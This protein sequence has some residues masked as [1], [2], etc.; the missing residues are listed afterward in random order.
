MKKIFTL[1]AV[2]FAAISL[3]AGELK[4]GTNDSQSSY[5]PVYVTW[6]DAYYCSQILY[7]ASELEALEGQKITHLAF[8]LRAVNTGGDYADVQIRFK[9]V[10]FDAFEEAAYVAIDDAVLVYEGALPAGSSTDLNV[11]L[12]EPYEY[13]GGT[14]LVDVRKTVKGGAYAPISGNAG[15]FQSTSGANYTVLYN[16][17]S[18]SFP[19]SASRSANRPDIRFTYEEGAV[20]ACDKITSLAASDVTAHEATLTWECEAEKYL[21]V[22]VLKGEEPA[23]TDNSQAVKTV[24]L[25]ALKSNTEYDFYVRS[26]CGEEQLGAPK[27]VSF[28]TEASCFAPLSVEA[29]DITAD[30][31]KMV[32]TPSGMGEA[33]YQCA[34][35]YAGLEP[36]SW[37]NEF[38]ATSILIGD[39]LQ[40]AT[41]Y[42]FYVRSYCGENDFSEPISVT[43]TTK[44]GTVTAPWKEDFELMDYETVPACWDNTASTT[45]SFET[46]PEYVWG[47]YATGD[48]NQ[49][50]RMYNYMLQEG[51]ALI[52]TPAINIPATSEFELSF[53][54]AHAATCGAFSVKISE[55]N[56]ASFVDLG[57]GYEKTSSTSTWS[58]GDYTNVVLSLKEFAGKEVILQFFAETDYDGGAIFVD[59]VEVREVNDDPSAIENQKSQITNRKFLKEGQLIIEYNG[60]RYNVLGARVNK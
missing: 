41:S 37:S 15:R 29:Q 39:I 49:M 32:W 25:D 22:C 21:F 31:A 33:Q 42:T 53:D 46:Y 18:S 6:A 60:V 54:Y 16:Y 1:F 9:E 57:T 27:K 43:F 5:A 35:M 28:K 12:A 52:N 20:A 24:T 23:W 3:S 48:G 17:G 40:P 56:G 4:I 44:C 8:L 50:I 55:D 30:G 51:T 19:T 11:E 13:Q 10:N 7:S 2:L 47:V 59:N 38:P 58:P 45:P 36:D 14:L 34:L 26:F